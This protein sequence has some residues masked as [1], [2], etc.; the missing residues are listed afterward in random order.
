MS[1]EGVSVSLQGNEIPPLDGGELADLRS[2]LDGSDRSAAIRALEIALT[3][4]GDGS[5]LVW[6][7]PERKL[8]GVIKPVA[9]F[10][11]GRG[12]ICRQIHYSIALGDYMREIE[13]AACRGTDGNW[14]YSG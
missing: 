1:A 10:R 9:A 12:R 5:T 13:G 11:D 3:E 14:H 6:R 2:H 7:R 8:M 4:L